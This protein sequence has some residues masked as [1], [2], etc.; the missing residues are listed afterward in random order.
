MTAYGRTHPRVAVVTGCESGTG[1][2]VAVALAES[3]FDV[4]ITRHRDVEHAQRTA[5]EVR[6]T[7]RRA[8]IRRLDLTCLPQAAGVVDDLAD[9]LGGLGVLVNCAGAGRSAP[10]LD[11][12]WTDW[13]QVLTVD[14][15]GP[16]LCAQRA[17]RRMVAADRGGR[18]INITGV[19]E[20]APRAGFGAY[21]A[22]KG[23]LGMLTRVMAKELGD[24]GITVNAVAPG[25]IAAPATYQEHV[26]PWSMR[27]PG[28]PL[29][30]PGGAH[31]VAAVVAFLAGD[32][33]SYVTGA[34]WPVDGGVLTMGP[35][36]G[37]HL[38]SDDWRRAGP[39]SG[40]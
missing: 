40:Q 13:R 7:G 19:H 39:D 1:R 14:L 10:I 3:G 11:T 12:S 34:S 18:I 20:T 23:G 32:E 8:E 37:S 38:A 6:K 30:R 2:A 15:D 24:H 27:R 33:S 9:A 29:G 28:I 36:A 4:G 21:C 35:A 25:E 22:A 31:E 16:F 17:A 26:Q 5:D